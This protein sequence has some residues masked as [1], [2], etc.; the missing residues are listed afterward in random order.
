LEVLIG[1]RLLGSD[2]LVQVSV[3]QLIHEVNV[4]EALLGRSWR[5]HDVYK[6]DNVFVLE[7]PEQRNLTKSPPGVCLI[8]ECVLNLLDGNLFF[9][10]CH[11]RGTDHSIRPFPNALDRLQGCLTL[12]HLARHS[13]HTVQLFYTS[14]VRRN[15]TKNMR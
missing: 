13:F 3:H 10:P 4:L 1:Q 6:L 9:A 7:L 2:D 11:S 8:L 5:L 15:A 12:R 14:K